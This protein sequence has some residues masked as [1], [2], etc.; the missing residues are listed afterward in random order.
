MPFFFNPITGELNFSTSGGDSDITSLVGDVT[1]SGTG[2]VTATVASVGGSTAA[3]VHSAEL[4]A[5]AAT[6]NNTNSTIVKRDSSGNFSAT[7]ITASLTGNAS[8]SA[9]S[10]TGS[11]SGDVTG[12][13]SSTTVATV[14][15]SSAANVHSAELAANAATSSRTA[16]TIVKRDTNWSF[17]A[18][19][20]DILNSLAPGIPGTPSLFNTGDPMTVG[21]QIKGKNKSI[22]PAYPGDLLFDAEYLTSSVNATYVS[23]GSTTG[24]AFN[25]AA[26]SG[27][28]LDM[29]GGTAVK[30]VDYDPTIPKN[31]MQIGTVRFRVK[32]GYSGAPANAQVFLQTNGDQFII[33]QQG[34][35]LHYALYVGASP[36][37]DI[38]TSFSPTSGT[39]YEMELDYN[40]TSGASTAFLDG[41]IVGTS[42]AT[43]TRN[44]ATITLFQSGDSLDNINS[45]FTIDDIVYYNTVQH[46]TNFVSPIIGYNDP[47]TQQS[48]L[49]QFLNDG[50]STLAKFDASANATLPTVIISSTTAST[51]P[52]LDTNKSIVSS[53]V[54]PTELGYVS[55][56][57]SSIQTQLN[58][59][60][61]AL[62][63]INARYFSS[64]TTISGSLA[65]IVYATQDYD[66]NTAY[67]SGTYTVPRAG[68]YQINAAL[69]ITGTIALNNN[70]IMEIQKNGTVVS[71]ETVY[72]P[73]TL[74]DGIAMI[75]D[76]INCAL[77]DTIRIQVS[78]SVTAPSIV[79][80]NF[81]NYLSL[82]WT[83][84]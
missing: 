35:T 83:G 22:T 76:L 79:S 23:V 18:G 56:V 46:T 50:G 5:N 4:L 8:G 45:N 64:T 14:G 13:Q 15:T 28:V 44:A 62:S 54:T 43:G 42:S 30:H 34:S 7:T 49:L 53:A 33:Y 52:Y 67:S 31:A 36:V 81:D 57:T 19:Y 2:A 61:A 9:A 51:V 1:A 47:Q 24:T 38:T 82:F 70:I 71:R 77:N 41:V 58:G 66:S 80:S 60:A 73:A 17:S 63:S 26:V 12:T 3:N 25:G 40:I 55:G 74:T 72:F 27:G 68:K 11:L 59:K 69:L 10:F 65:T 39:L 29:L 37:F 32:P 16:N 48:D 78:T 20:L 84:A 75:S 6:N 21:L